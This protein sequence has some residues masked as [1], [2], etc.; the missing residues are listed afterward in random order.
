MFCNFSFVLELEQ[1][2][3]LATKLMSIYKLHD[4]LSII[5]DLYDPNSLFLE[6]YTPSVPKYKM[7]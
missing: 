1:F 6:H 4:I 2:T 5:M 7:F 3:Y